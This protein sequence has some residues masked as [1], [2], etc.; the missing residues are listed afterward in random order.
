[1]SKLESIKLATDSARI[2]KPLKFYNFCDS[3]RGYRYDK[4][5]NKFCCDSCPRANGFHADAA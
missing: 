2:K 4:Y 5:G 3:A 1:M